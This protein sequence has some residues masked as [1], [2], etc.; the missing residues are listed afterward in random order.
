MR[1]PIFILLLLAAASAA[2]QGPDARYWR[3]DDIDAQLAAWA[4]AYP[5]I[6][7]LDTLGFSGQGEAIPVLRVSARVDLDEPEPCLFFHAAQHANEVNGTGAVMRSIE[8]LLTGYGVQADVTA[9]VD[10]LDLWFAPVINVDGHRYVFDENPNWQDWRKT[11]RDYDGDGFPDFPTDGVDTNRNWDWYW[12]EYSSSDP[13]KDKGP[14][15]FSEPEARA[16]RDFVLDRRPLLVVDYHSPVTITWTNYVFYPWV[17]QHG[18]GNS[19]DYDVARDLAQDWAAATKTHTGASY[20]DIWSYDSLPKEQCWVYGRTGSIAYIMEISD[21]CWWTGA[22]VDTIA[23]RVARGADVLLDRGVGGPGIRGVV[24]DA[25]TGAPLVAEVKIHQ[26]H[27][28]EVGPRLTE[29]RNGGYHRLTLAADYDLTVTCPGYYPETRAVTVP[30]GSGWVTA[31]FALERDPTA[32]EPGT[33]AAAWLSFRNPM[34]AGGRVRLSL[35][36][37]AAA[38]AVALYD[39]RGRRVAALGDGLASGAE[40]DLALPPELAAGVYLLRLRSGERTAGRRLVLLR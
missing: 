34:P 29:A 38:A 13:Q 39:V 11:L 19:P 23:V 25:G 26:L 3:L 40:H 1:I 2:A 16:I 12:S 15:P 24:T 5:Q 9:R 4:A 18:H 8:R 28:D 14:E 17:S 22:N 36:A 30:G 20:G 35:P 32:V 21:H 10:A 31:D 37:G 27:G 33:D 7:R 6:A